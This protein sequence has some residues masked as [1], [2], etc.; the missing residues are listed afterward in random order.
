[1]ENN[2]PI[3]PPPHG[4]GEIPIVQ[5]VHDFYLEFHKALIDFPKFTKHTLGETTQH[6]SLQMLEALL[7]AGQ[8]SPGV[9]KYNFLSEANAK[10]LLLKLLVRM[11][12][13]TKAISD[14]KYIAL[15]SRLQTI[16]K[17]LG[18]WM[19]TSKIN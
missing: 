12:F 2:F 9:N 18:G 5:A 19:R 8:S 17:M 10:L 14:K 3:K 11:C 6:C 1:M 13:E 4:F 7:S 15:Q 16:G